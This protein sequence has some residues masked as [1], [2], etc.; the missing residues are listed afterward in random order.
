V[1]VWW[2]EEKGELKERK[3]WMNKT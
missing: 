2:L 3:E 1:D